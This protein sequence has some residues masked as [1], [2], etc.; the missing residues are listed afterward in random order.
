MNNKIL[1]KGAVIASLA[2][3][4][5][6]NVSAQTPITVGLDHVGMNVP[7]IDSAIHFFTDVMGFTP[8][9]EIGPLKLD[10]AWKKRYR[11]RKNAEVKKIVMIQA[12]SGASIE[13][14]EYKSADRN[15]QLPYGD[16]LGWFHIGFY[17]DDIDKSVAYLKSKGVN[18]LNDP[19]KITTGP[20]AGETWVYFVTP[21]GLQIELVSYADGKAYENNAPLIKLWSPKD[22]RVASTATI[23]PELSSLE[24]EALIKHHLQIWSETDGI[25]RSEAIKNIYN[26]KITIIDPLFLLNGQTEMNQFI[27]KLQQKYPGYVFSISRPI[28]SHHNTARLFWQFGPVSKPDAITGQDVFVIENRKIQSLYVFLD[29]E[30]D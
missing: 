5:S 14:F 22:H 12:G 26:E 23:K 25:K 2:L 3:S 11:I 13:L 1:R 10:D 20:T 30:K 19:I 24:T 4:A 6:L 29:K 18:V 15:K 27:E 9:T 21:W 8:V 16:D 7:D 17:T 28:E